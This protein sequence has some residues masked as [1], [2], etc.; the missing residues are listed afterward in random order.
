MVTVKY[1]RSVIASV[2]NAQIMWTLVQQQLLPWSG[3]L[4]RW[5][6]IM[7]TTKLWIYRTMVDLLI[8]ASS[9][10]AE[11]RAFLHC[12]LSL[13]VLTAV[14]ASSYVILVAFS[15]TAI[16]HFL[17]NLGL[18]YHLL[19]GRFQ[20]SACLVML[21]RFFLLLCSSHLHF[22]S[23]IFCPIGFSF[24]LLQ[25]ALFVIFFWPS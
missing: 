25:S 1:L 8:Y 17:V 2:E 14:L 10:Q 23:I 7:F 5:P 22:H 12:L 19:P 18:P 9:F 11:H 4:W 15:S 16:L 24:I 20:S 6:D 3:P 21:F 13:Q